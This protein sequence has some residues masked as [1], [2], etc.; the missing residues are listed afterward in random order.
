MLASKDKG[1]LIG[2]HTSVNIDTTLILYAMI[3]PYC[4]I[5]E[6]VAFVEDFFEILK[7]VHCREK[8]HIGEK[9]Q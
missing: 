5:E 7:E 2:Y 1:L 9:R 4:Q 6:R 3:Q 8:G